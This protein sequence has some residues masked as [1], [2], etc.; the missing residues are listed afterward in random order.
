MTHLYSFAAGLAAALGL[1]LAVNFALPGGMANMLTGYDGDPANPWNWVNVHLA[2]W[3]AF[4]MG[5]ASVW[6]IDR[7]LRQ[8]RSWAAGEF[9]DRDPHSMYDRED[10]I[11]I[12]SSV[13]DLPREAIVR[14]MIQRPLAQ[15]QGS[16][17]WS[18]A[19]EVLQA[20][21]LEIQ[22]RSDLAYTVPRYLSWLVPTLGFVG[23]VLG[24]SH[25]LAEV[26]LLRPEDFAE[27][28]FLPPVVGALGIAF[29]TTLIALVLAGVL[30][31]YI[32]VVQ[33]A[34]DS[35]VTDLFGDC[36]E[37]LLNKLHEA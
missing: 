34:E 19:N 36:V 12:Y 35:F 5:M 30:I 18:Q 9:L 28:T 4:F 3:T 11:A 37:N 7:L 8:Q 31:L 10:R 2:I 27:A 17:S 14:Q 1:F 33:A 22:S 23:T 26:G 16:K 21:A 15:Y 32:S 13:S 20:T 24:I 6:Q 25:A 29:S